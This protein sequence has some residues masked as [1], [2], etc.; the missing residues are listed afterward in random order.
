M[1]CFKQ[2]S[3]LEFVEMIHDRS[4][5]LTLEELKQVWNFIENLED[6]ILARMK[7][8]IDDRKKGIIE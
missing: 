1:D 8:K 5:T 3:K 6:P 2:E 4:M 7:K